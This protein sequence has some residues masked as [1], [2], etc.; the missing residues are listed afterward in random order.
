MNFY[1]YPIFL[2]FHICNNYH[3]Y[4]IN[5]LV[6][7]RFPDYIYFKPGIAFNFGPKN[8]IATHRNIIIE[9]HPELFLHFYLFFRNFHVVGPF[10]QPRFQFGQLHINDSRTFVHDRSIIIHLGCTSTRLGPLPLF[11]HH[12]YLYLSHFFASL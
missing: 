4:R 9:H 12:H 2:L 5:I 1:R 3:R 11:H 8:L 10:E 6:R 7:Y